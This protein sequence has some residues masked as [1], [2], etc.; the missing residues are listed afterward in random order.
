MSNTI[1]ADDLQKQLAKY[2]EEYRE[3][4]EEDVEESV[5]E[6]T[7]KAKEELKADS[8]SKFKLHGRETPY[9]RGW[10]VKLSKRDR[11]KYV[12]VIWNRTNYQLT[13]LLEFGHATRNGGRTKAV[14]HI[15]PIE[16]KYNQKFV[17]LITQ[18]I[19]RQK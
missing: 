6:T 5:D 1:K 3:D 19:R 18:K 10:S 13:H 11:T 15:R 14:P 16:E 17:D 9:Y 2:L 8:Q 7:E 12:K 4:I